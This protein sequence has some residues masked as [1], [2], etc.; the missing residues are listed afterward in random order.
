M[1]RRTFL[2]TLA[3]LAVGRAGAQPA[4]RIFKVGILTTTGNRGQT[5]FYV[6]LEDRFRELG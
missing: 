2:L 1:K 6:S 5:P 4:G 3:A